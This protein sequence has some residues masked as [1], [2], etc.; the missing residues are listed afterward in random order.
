MRDQYIYRP[1]M[2]LLRAGLWGRLPDTSLFPLGADNWSE[3]R[4]MAQRQTVSGILYDGLLLLPSELHPPLDILMAWLNEVVSIEDRNQQM[5]RVLVESHA[6]L[7]GQGVLLKLLKGQ[8]IA[9]FYRNPN[10]RT[11]G[12]IDWFCSSVNDI[13]KIEKI[14][15]RIKIGVTRQSGYTLFYCWKGVAVEHHLKL[16]DSHNPFLRSYVSDLENREKSKSMYLNLGGER[17]MLPSPLM[18]VLLVNLHILKHMLSFGI[19]LRQLCDSAC[20]ISALSVQLDGE[21]LKKIYKK[22]GIYQWVLVLHEVLV[23]ELGLD[24]NK[25]PFPCKIN[26]KRADWLIEEVW[27]CGNFGFYDKR[28]GGHDMQTYRRK[29]ILLHWLRRFS[30]HLF[31]APQETIF[32][33]IAQFF[34]R[35]LK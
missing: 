1:F 13:S 20:L 6:F 12:D 30:I 10:H 21:E 11:C 22:L 4:K 7:S 34:S 24:E 18:T 29:H 31:L 19:G 32:F 28:F 14:L 9:A 17:I 25:L 26:T 8:G 27:T 35:F 15:N 16:L 33:P 23:F 3:V 2:E 5:N